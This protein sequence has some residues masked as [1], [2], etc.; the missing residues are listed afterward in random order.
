MAIHI[1]DK[2]EKGLARERRIK[3]ALRHPD[4]LGAGAKKRRSLSKSENTEALAREFKRGT[5]RSGSG[6]K[7]KSRAQL[8]AII[9][10][11]SKGR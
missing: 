9:Y 10:S 4:I 11:T 2:I 7:V 8:R 6:A 3:E 5:L 1:H